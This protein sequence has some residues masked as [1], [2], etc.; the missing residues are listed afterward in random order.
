[1]RDVAG[2][3]VL[4]AIVAENGVRE[5][6]RTFSISGGGPAGWAGV[7]GVVGVGSLGV[8]AAGWKVTL[9]NAR[10]LR[11]LAYGALNVTSAELTAVER[12]A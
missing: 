6:V 1:M 12:D 11:S 3:L 8:P 9:G 10:N 4:Q 7:V 5:I 2:T